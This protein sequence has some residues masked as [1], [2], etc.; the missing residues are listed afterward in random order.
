[1]PQQTKTFRVFVSSTFS[2]MREERRILQE[3]VFPDLQRYCESRGAKFQAIDL[4]WGVS[5]ESRLDNKTMDICL[6]EIR[7]CLKVSPR[8]NFLILLGDRYGWQPPPARIPQEEMGVILNSLTAGEKDKLLRWYRKD[9]NAIPAQYVLLARKGEYKDYRRWAP[10]EKSLLDILRRGAEASQ[11]VEEKKIKY[12]ASATHQEIIHGT[13]NPH[14]DYSGQEEHVFACLMTISN[15]QEDECMGDFVEI[16]KGKFDP[17]CREA[18][19][20]LR[21]E[22]E[23]KLPPSNVHKY[24]G[25]LKKGKDGQL[26]LSIEK[27]KLFAAAV[28]DH[29]RAVIDQEIEKVVGIDPLEKE[30]NLHREFRNT[31]LNHFRGREDILKTIH[32]FISG[33]ES[34][35]FCLLGESGSGKSSIMAKAMVEAQGRYIIAYRFC[36]ISPDSS[37]IRSTIY[38]LTQ[39]IARHYQVLQK[40]LLKEEKKEGDKDTPDGKQETT[41]DITKDTGLKKVFHKALNLVTEER[42]LVL[43]LDAIDQLKDPLGAVLDWFPGKMPNY[44]WIVLSSLMDSEDK[45][46]DRFLKQAIPPMSRN[47]GEMI[48]EEWFKAEERKLQEDQKETIL[49]RFRENGLPVY[50]RL[51]FEEAKFWRSFDGAPELKADVEAVLEDYFERLEKE[52]GQLLVERF[53][54]YLLC[55]KDRGLGEGEI[56]DLL[57]FDNEYWNEFYNKSHPLHKSELERVRKLPI[58]VWSRFYLDLEPYLTTREGEGGNILTFFHRQ[59][60]EFAQKQYVTD[61]KKLHSTMADYFETLPLYFDNTWKTPNGRKCAEQPYQQIESE[62]WKDLTKKTLGDFPFLM[63][64][65]KADMVEGILNDYRLAFTKAPEDAKKK[66]KSW[67]AFFRERAHI[68]RR[69]NEE[70][71]AYKILLQL[72]VEHADESPVTLEAECFLAKGKC[73]WHSLRNARRLSRLPMNPLLD[74]LGGHEGPVL[75]TL[76][77][78]DGRIISWSKDLT[79][80]LWDGETGA[81]LAVLEGHTSFIRTVLLLPNGRIVSCPEGEDHTLRLWDPQTGTPLAVLEGHTTAVKGARLLSDGRILS[82]SDAPWPQSL[83]GGTLCLWDGQTGAPLSVLKGHTGTINGASLLPDGRILHPLLVGGSHPTSLG[84]GDGRPSCCPQGTYQGRL[85]YPGST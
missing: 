56:L 4:R 70:W 75:G 36:G 6:G 20:A 46:G 24:R 80:R 5:E 68:L 37:T 45:I 65:T 27:K 85:G 67:E 76:I 55:G 59:F 2:D 49:E 19:A 1:M 7:R 66:L 58:A 61:I 51:T 35:L 47:E 8:P 34:K 48:L 52:H 41:I 16:T 30:I 57:A 31:L 72:A 39:E 38:S 18:L 22:I 25:R 81:P 83:G 29:F 64:K 43:F 44:C 3:K 28:Y 14:E 78:G 77:I 63:A 82:W 17:Y 26:Q 60:T 73:D 15:L 13:L 74:V 42:P 54:G 21:R 12:L 53:C 23:K 11:L 50:L 9:E 84:W 71:P 33:K 10:V 62:Q 32:E 69:G 40:N 79:L